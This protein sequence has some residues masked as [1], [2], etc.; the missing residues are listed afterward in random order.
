MPPPSILVIF[1]VR[2]HLSDIDSTHVKVDVCDKAILVST[3]IKNV[4]PFHAVGIGIRFPNVCKPLPCHA[5]NR[6]MPLLQ[7]RLRRRMSI[8]ELLEFCVTEDIHIAGTAVY[9]NRCRGTMPIIF[10]LCED[11]KADL[12]AN[13][14]IPCIRLVEPSGSIPL[15]SWLLARQTPSSLSSMRLDPLRGHRTI[16][17]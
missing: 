12:N 13:Q 17:T 11:V 9:S 7:W 4:A 8:P 1:G 6:L 10:A 5:T 16:S 2:K 3:D 15:P 14:K